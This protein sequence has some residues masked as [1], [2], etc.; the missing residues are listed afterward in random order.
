MALKIFLLNLL[1]LKPG[2][3]YITKRIMVILK[4]SILINYKNS[5]IVI[6]NAKIIIIDFFIL[7]Y[8]N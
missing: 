7:D 5:F 8:N 4:K 2:M 1:N 6:S 3:F